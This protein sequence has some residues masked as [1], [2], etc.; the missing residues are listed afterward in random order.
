MGAASLADL[1]PSDERP[2]A[3]LWDPRTTQLREAAVERLFV[4]SRAAFVHRACRPIQGVDRS[5]LVP[6]EFGRRTLGGE[7][8][9]TGRLED[10]IPSVR[11]RREA[12]LA[13]GAEE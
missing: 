2:K 9:L 13:A 7:A 6:V 10:L 3:R 8:S 12:F 11:A 1:A 5:A 4:D